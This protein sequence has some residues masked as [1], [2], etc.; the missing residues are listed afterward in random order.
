MTP[1]SL[2]HW[3]SMKIVVPIVFGMVLAIVQIVG[4]VAVNHGLV[5]AVFT[6]L[7]RMLLRLSVPGGGQGSRR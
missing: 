2:D 6:V 1:K 5:L 3:R 7:V 4:M